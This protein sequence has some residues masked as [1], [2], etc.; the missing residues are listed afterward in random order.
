MCTL[1][2]CPTGEHGKLVHSF[3]HQCGRPALEVV[4]PDPPEKVVTI[5]REPL[6][7]GVCPDC[8]FVISFASAGRI[9]FCPGCGASIQW[10]SR[11]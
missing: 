10:R 4:L 11:Y 5:A 7:N 9:Y 3:C 1:K 6:S 8:T 2:I